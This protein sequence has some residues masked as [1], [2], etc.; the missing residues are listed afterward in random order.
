MA[1][2]MSAHK[3]VRVVWCNLLL[4]MFDQETMENNKYQIPEDNK[5]PA[6]GTEVRLDLGE[7]SG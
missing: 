7:E 2:W 1:V 3:D 4:S 5:A 6:T